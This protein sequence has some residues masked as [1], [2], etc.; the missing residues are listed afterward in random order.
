MGGEEEDLKNLQGSEFDTRF[1]STVVE[2][3]DK[4]IS[5]L[6]GFKGQGDK[7]LDKLIDQS[8]QLL[9]DHRD[10]AQKLQQRTPAA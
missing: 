10:E 2:S 9:E 1:L 7:K 3:A 8:V 6:Q 4:S 5:R